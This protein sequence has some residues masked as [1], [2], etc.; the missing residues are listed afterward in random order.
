MFVL[1]R[2]A[3]DN[4]L[5]HDLFAI[6]LRVHM[7]RGRGAPAGGGG[8]GGQQHFLPRPGGTGGTK[9]PKLTVSHQ[10]S[11]RH[12]LPT[13]RS[14]LGSAGPDDVA[15]TSASTADHPAQ[16]ITHFISVERGRRS[17]WES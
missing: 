17:S 16:R 8:K 2:V 6:D 10:W 12:L 15:A 9:L 4:H 3:N 14:A 13:F 7:Q 1:Q 5:G 11:R